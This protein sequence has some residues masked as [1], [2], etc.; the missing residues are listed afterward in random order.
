MERACIEFERDYYAVT[1]D[2][3]TR[4]DNQLREN[5]SA[6][7][8]L[9]LVKDHAAYQADMKSSFPKGIP[10]PIPDGDAYLSVAK[11]QIRQ[12]GQEKKGMVTP[13]EKAF[14]RARQANLRA[15]FAAYKELQIQALAPIL[16]I[17][18]QPNAPATPVPVQPNAPAQVQQS[19]IPPKTPAQGQQP[20]QP[21]KTK[22]QTQAKNQSRG[23]GGR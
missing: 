14:L 16:P 6:E 12:L 2:D 10:L 21:T 8:S 4:L 5:K 7:H 18:V 20:P 11:I 3:M 15:G 9:T 23:D 13:H 17:Q 19:L 22:G 1:S